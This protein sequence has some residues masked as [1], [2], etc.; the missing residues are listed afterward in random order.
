MHEIVYVK[1]KCTSLIIGHYIG[2]QFYELEYLA[3]QVMK[4]QLRCLNKMI[5]VMWQGVWR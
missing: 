4:I 5:Y 1:S 2:Q 3:F